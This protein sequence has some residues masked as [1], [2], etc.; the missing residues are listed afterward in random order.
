MVSSIF[1]GR[2]SERKG[3]AVSNAMPHELSEDSYF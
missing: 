1:K 3:N 2:R